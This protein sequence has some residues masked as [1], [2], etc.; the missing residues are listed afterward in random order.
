M[1]TFTYSSSVNF[2]KDYRNWHGYYNV[3]NCNDVRLPLKDCPCNAGPRAATQHNIS[4]IGLKDMQIYS[5]T[6]VS[7]LS[8]TII[9]FGIGKLR[10][11]PNKPNFMVNIFLKK[12]HWSQNFRTFFPE[13]IAPK[14]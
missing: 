12:N 5:A 13:I 2:G 14:S 4:I 10:L 7:N 11:R 9:N 8:R 3:T 6:K 1:T